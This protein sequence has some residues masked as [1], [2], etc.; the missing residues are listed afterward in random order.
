M[1]KFITC[2]DS[3]GITTN[4]LGRTSLERAALVI[5]HLIDGYAD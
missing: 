1:L 2:S 3:G 5:T 4:V